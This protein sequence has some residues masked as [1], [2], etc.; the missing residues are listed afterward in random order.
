[1]TVPFTDGQLVK[2]VELLDGF[3][4]WAVVDNGLLWKSIGS[5]IQQ[6]QFELSPLAISIGKISVA[7]YDNPANQLGFIVANDQAMNESQDPLRRRHH[8]KY[9]HLINGDI[10]NML[11]RFPERRSFL[12]RREFWTDILTSGGGT[13]D[14]AAAASARKL[15]ATYP[16]INPNVIKNSIRFGTPQFSQLLEWENEFRAHFPELNLSP[17]SASGQTMI[18]TA[19]ELITAVNLAIARSDSGSEITALNQ[20]IESFRRNDITL[21]QA[22]LLLGDIQNITKEDIEAIEPIELVVNATFERYSTQDQ[23]NTFQLVTVFSNS[24]ITPDHFESLKLDKGT[25]LTNLDTGEIFQNLDIFQ[26][27]FP[28]KTT[29]V[30]QLFATGDPNFFIAGTADIASIEVLGIVK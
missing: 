16:N 3:Q 14:K 23:G 11:D 5:A 6:I 13:Q 17:I 24:P 30:T 9:F 18:T 20:I 1:M 22:I 7:D 2:R 4:K 10:I 27:V 29:P 8:V 25:R 26:F 28:D 21:E 12:E 19:S 15:T